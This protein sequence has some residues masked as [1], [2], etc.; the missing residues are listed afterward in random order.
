MSKTTPDIIYTQQFVAA[1]IQ[2]LDYSEREEA[3]DLLNDFNLETGQSNIQHDTDENLAGYLGYTDRKAATRLE[4][5]LENVYPTFTNES[6]NLT[7]QQHA[8]LADQIR[9]AQ[10]NKS[11]LW[12]GV[13]SFDPE[14]LESAKLYDPKTNNVNQR[15]IKRAIQKAVPEMLKQENLDVPETFWWADIHLN[16]NHVHVH[17]GISQTKNTRALKNNG[18]PTGMFKSKSLK[19]IKSIVHREVEND[20]DRANDLNLEK[21]LVD[22]KRNLVEQLQENLQRE[23]RQQQ[24]LANIFQALP[25]YKDKRRWRASNNS[26]DFREAKLLTEKLVD[27][28]L[29]T[30]LKNDYN[31]YLTALKQRDLRAREKYGQNIDDTVEKNKQLLKDFLMNRVFDVLR[32]IKNPYDYKSNFTQ[33]VLALGIE[34]NNKLID[35]LQQQLKKLDPKSVEAKSLKKEIGIRKYH[36]RILNQQVRNNNYLALIDEIRQSGKKNKNQKYL[37]N[38]LKE[39]YR[40]NTLKLLPK[41]QL[42]DNLKKEKLQLEAKHFDVKKISIEKINQELVDSKNRYLNKWLKVVKH[43]EDPNVKIFLESQGLADKDLKNYVSTLKS[44]MVIKL[45][46]KEN[47]QNYAKQD[48]IRK[49]KNGKLFA[50]LKKQYANLESSNSDTLYKN[51]QLSLNRSS[52]NTSA[53]KA[54]TKNKEIEQQKQRSNFNLRL[55]SMLTKSLNQI[56][57]SSAEEIRAKRRKLDDE[58]LDR[59]DRID[60]IEIETGRSMER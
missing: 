56:K 20:I 35:A 11:L 38:N 30:D 25:K 54:K 9:R 29:M 47:N 21:E 16:T 33:R 37:I 32:E 46:I 49:K 3:V 27:D 53:K 60:E 51:L 12:Q 55:G 10:K 57:A 13:I 40:L 14:F 24:M 41:Q 2:Y 8:K 18:E 58:E 26:Y 22:L 36:V 34:G 5:G 23:Q 45:K 48:S 42:T 6:L 31:D 43:T 7:Y 44:I 17:I 52:Q 59:E 19:K 39:K 1:N 28:L 15:L 50:E 4:E